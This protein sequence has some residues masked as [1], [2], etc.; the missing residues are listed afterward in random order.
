MKMNEL[1][2][3][4]GQITYSYSRIDFL[5]SY[6]A[7]DF[8]M[9][10]SP[11]MCFA[12][13]KFEKKIDL[14]NERINKQIEKIELI[15]EFEA[16]TSKLHEL[17]ETRNNLLHSLILTNS[18]NKNDFMFYNYRFD[19]SSNLIRVFNHYN[20]ADLKELNQ[21]YIDIYNEGFKLWQKFKSHNVSSTK[22]STI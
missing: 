20:I 18:E 7:Y 14:L 3:I 22:N 2:P 12:K 8:G 17:R 4:L 6:M 13:S 10:E 9:T 15:R 5:I 1:Y 19:K 21:N 11:Y 16:W